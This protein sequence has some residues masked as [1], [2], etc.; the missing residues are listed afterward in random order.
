MESECFASLSSDPLPQ[1]SLVTP[2]A[3]RG[4]EGL[5]AVNRSTSGR[6]SKVRIFQGLREENRF[7]GHQKGS[8][9]PTTDAIRGALEPQEQSCYVAGGESYC[10]YHGFNDRT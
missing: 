7:L 8:H 3:Y 2:A 6:S 10:F 9:L 5:E 4:V 1:E